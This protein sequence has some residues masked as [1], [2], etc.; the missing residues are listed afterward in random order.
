MESCLGGDQ[1][2][3]GRYKELVQTLNL[4]KLPIHKQVEAMYFNTFTVNTCYDEIPPFLLR[5]SHTRPKNR[6]QCAFVAFT[7]ESSFRMRI[8]SIHL[9]R[10]IGTE[11]IVY[12]SNNDK[13]RMVTPPRT[14]SL[15]KLSRLGHHRRCIRCPRC[16]L[17]WP[18][19]LRRH[20]LDAVEK[21]TAYQVVS[22]SS[23]KFTF[24]MKSTTAKR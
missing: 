13:L 2:E 19:M 5:P 1:R 8:E 7:L 9:W 20:W 22:C 12:S 14:A 18:I 4:I 23:S 16:E 24:H 3:T 10:W 15:S 6:I 11:F 17:R 21:E